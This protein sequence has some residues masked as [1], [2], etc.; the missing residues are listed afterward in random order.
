M[1]FEIISNE[2][3]ITALI[4]WSLPWKGVTLWKSARNKQK[5]WFIASLLLNTFTILEIVYLGFFQ[6]KKK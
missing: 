6:K 5:K 1:L 3:F 4:I 2:W